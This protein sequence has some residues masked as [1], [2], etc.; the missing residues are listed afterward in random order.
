MFAHHHDEIG[1]PF[2][3][4]RRQA[5]RSGAENPAGRNGKAVQSDQNGSATLLR[6]MSRRVF[7]AHG[8]LDLEAHVGSPEV[9]VRIVRTV[10]GLVLLIAGI[11]M[12]ALPGPGW[13]TIAAGLAILARE[14]HWARRLL[15]W[16]RT[17]AAQFGL[18][19][20]RRNQ[21]GAANGDSR[22]SSND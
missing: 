7:A 12:L 8:T 15:S 13:V 20:G 18:K 9:M 14:F 2:N 17:T 21:N 1:A 22:R 19:L 5:L 11:A 4:G 16:L 3:R 10:A 6:R